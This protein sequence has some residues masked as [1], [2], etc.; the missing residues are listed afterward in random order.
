M[1][2][3]HCLGCRNWGCQV[4]HDDGT[5]VVLR[6]VRHYTGH[7]FAITHVQVPVIRSCYGQ[8]G[9]GV[10]ADRARGRGSS[11]GGAA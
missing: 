4:G 1:F 2:A 6:S 8:A 3:T 9:A 11:D 5:P 7:G 10:D